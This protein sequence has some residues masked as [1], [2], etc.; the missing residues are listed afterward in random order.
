MYLWGKNPSPSG[1]DFSITLKPHAVGM[2]SS[3]EQEI[4]AQPRMPSGMR[5]K[6]ERLHTCGMPF[7]VGF[8]AFSTEL[9]IPMGCGH[10]VLYEFLLFAASYSFTIFT[11]LFPAFRRYNP[12]A[13]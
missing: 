2:Q 5:T 7:V 9:C 8:A 1:E 12:F 6:L 3:V 4:S 13:K 11:V 10:I